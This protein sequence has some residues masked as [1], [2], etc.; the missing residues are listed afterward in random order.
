MSEYTQIH[1]QGRG[2]C[3]RGVRYRVLTV[4]QIEHNERQIATELSKES[5]MM[6]YRAKVARLGLEEMIIAVSDPVTP[7][8]IMSASWKA[9]TG[10]SLSRDWSTLFNAKDTAVLKSIYA[11]EHT[12]SQEELDLIMAGKQTVLVEE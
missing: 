9:V 3:Q 5:S 7:E 11:N 4:D 6:E 2:M 8:K 12:V 1:L 10:D